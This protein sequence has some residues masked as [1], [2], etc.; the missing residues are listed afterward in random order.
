MNIAKMLE[1]IA[2]GPEKT[3]RAVE[4][5]KSVVIAILFVLAVGM[6]IRFAVM[7]RLNEAGEKQNGYYKISASIAASEHV[8]P[9][10]VL[11]EAACFESG[12]ERLMLIANEG[13]QSDLYTSLA[14]FIAKTLS[15]SGETVGADEAAFVGDYLRLRYH[16]PLP[17]AVIVC[18]AARG[19]NGDAQACA[20]GTLISELLIKN[21]CLYAISAVGDVKRYTTDE[22]T[23]YPDIASLFT[24]YSGVMVEYKTAAELGLSGIRADEPVI[25][26]AVVT[27]TMNVTNIS[28]QIVLSNAEAFEAVIRLFNFN[29]DKLSSGGETGGEYYVE[30]HGILRMD[31][32]GIVYKA[33]T[34]GGLPLSDYLSDHGSDGYTISDAIEAADS[35]TES[36]RDINPHLIGGDGDV[37]LLSVDAQGGALTIKYG[38]SFDNVLLTGF[39]VLSVTVDNGMITSVELNTF[40]ASDLSGVER[41]WSEVWYLRNV[42]RIP[43]GADGVAKL[44]YPA[45][46]SALSQSAGWTVYLPASGDE[47]KGAA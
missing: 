13:A 18:S 17:A 47:S 24:M 2:V 26:G 16:R 45:D 9:S 31:I 21:G 22:E 23:E 44:E 36:L 20:D 11:P 25:T 5:A 40:T 37:T 1:R 3:N 14:P 19:T 38:A 28:A 12:G 41:S 29:P 10:K 39:T 42:A 43:P 15:S 27:K 6:C 30:T 46:F 8:A 4:A 32:D 35:I 7:L 34:G 33:T